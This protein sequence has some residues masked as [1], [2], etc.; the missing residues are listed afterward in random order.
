MVKVL[1]Q[2]LPIL[3][4]ALINWLLGRVWAWRRHRILRISR[5]Q[6]CVTNMSKYGNKVPKA[7]WYRI[8]SW[9]PKSATGVGWI[10]P[11]IESADV[12]IFSRAQLAPVKEIIYKFVAHCSTH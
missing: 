1:Q 11:F 9:Q 6:A 3:T 2:L 8:I 4:A 5:N 7:S 12:I 10:I